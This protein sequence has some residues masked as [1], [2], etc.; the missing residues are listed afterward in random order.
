VMP[1]VC[2]SLLAQYEGKTQFANLW[3][4]NTKKCSN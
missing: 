3:L 2:S 1:G 4:H